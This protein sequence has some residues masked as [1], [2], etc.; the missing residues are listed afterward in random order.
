[1][2][3]RQLGGFDERFTPYGWEDVDLCLRA[4]AAGWTTL[5]V[6]GA[7]MA[8]HGTNIGRAP[9]PGYE[10]AKARNYPVLLRRHARPWH[11]AALAVCLPLRL[12]GRVAWLIRQGQGRIIR[13]HVR[14]LWEAATAYVSN[15]RRRVVAIGLEATEP[16][17]I[18]RWTAAGRLPALGSLM[19]RGVWRRLRSTTEISSGATWASVNTG[20]NPGKHGMG[21]YH[22]QL[23][24]GTYQLRKKYAEEVGRESFRVPLSDAGRR[25]AVL[26]VPET[27]AVPNFNGAQLM[28]WG[29]EGLNAPQASWPRPLFNRLAGRYGRHP[30]E[31]WYQARPTTVE[32][33]SA[34][35]DNLLRGA[36]VRSALIRDVQSQE[37]WDLLLAAFAEPHWAGHFFWHL[38][39][40]QHP[41]FDEALW[42]VCGD[43]ILRVYQALD[44][45]VGRLAAQAPDATLL[46][47]SNTGMGS[48]FSGMHLV[49]EILRRLGMAPSS[50]PSGLSDWLP[51]R[52]GPY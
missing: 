12:L 50:R 35:C 33:W 15:S 19:R 36:R 11:W 10:R 51:A 38:M 46:V 27:Y 40:P 3:L 4:R 43:A 26:D 34:L 2:V 16:S 30:L 14:G 20:T 48:N 21:F 49:P 42:R 1:A 29:T 32:G 8:H 5:Y 23:R 39:E 52:R 41:D 44:A 45:A 28:G 6:P 9:V 18:E 24:C 47:F 31:R 13:V 7:V 17:L 37:P 22:R 25:V